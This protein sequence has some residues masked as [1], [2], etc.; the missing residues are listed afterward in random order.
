MFVPLERLFSDFSSLTFLLGPFI[1]VITL[2]KAYTGF[3]RVINLEIG[4]FR[5]A[6]SCFLFWS[7]II[8]KY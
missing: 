4:L 7:I 8:E 3:E 2:S 6:G 5:S 1:L